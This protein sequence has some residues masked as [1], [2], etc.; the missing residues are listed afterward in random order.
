MLNNSARHPKPANRTGQLDKWNT[1]SFHQT[2]ILVMGKQIG[3]VPKWQTPSA[4]KCKILS[5]FAL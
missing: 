3:S 5:M 4:E 1:D 2:A